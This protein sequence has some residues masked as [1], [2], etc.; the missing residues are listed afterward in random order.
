MCGRFTLRTPMKDVVRLFELA[1]YDDA[2]TGQFKERFNI[3]PSQPIAA[4]RHDRAQNRRELTW[5]RW[6][7]VPPWA[8][9]PAV[10]N[11]M[12]NARAETVATRPAFREALRQRRCLI[13]ADGFYEW[14]RQHGAKQP[15]FISL[16][17][18]E[19]FA[20]AG[21]WE[22]WQRGELTIESCTI[23][24]TSANELLRPLHNRMPAIVDAE[25]FQ[26]WLD[27]DIEDIKQLEDLLS[28]YPADRLTAYPVRSVVNSPFHDAADCVERAVPDKTQGSL[29]D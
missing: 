26:R 5:L 4:V 21:L 7:L 15:F 14:K 29:F 3:A 2:Q 25:H 24:T 20:F 1:H 28:A 18:S 13:P 8:D 17:G 16:K 10:G 9:D 23:I 12:I 11:Q 27:P 6:G 19:P 22:R